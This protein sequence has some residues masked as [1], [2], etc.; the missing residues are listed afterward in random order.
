M[1]KKLLIAALILVAVVCAFASCKMQNTKEIK[2]VT[3]VNV[4]EDPILVGHFDEAGIE[5]VITYTDDTTDRVPVTESLCPSI[6]QRYLNEEGSFELT[7]LYRGFE[8]SFSV[9]MHIENTWTIRFFNAFG[10]VVKTVVM[11]ELSEGTPIPP[12]AEE[13]YC[14]GYI[15]LGTYDKDFEHATESMDVYG[16]Y[17]KT[18]TVDFYNGRNVLVSHQVVKEG[19]NATAPTGN[20]IQVPSYDFIGWDN[21]YTDIHADTVV[22]GIYTKMYAPNH[23]SVWDGTIATSYDGGLGTS[24]DP[25]RIGSASQLARMAGQTSSTYYVLTADID[26]AGRPWT[27]KEFSGYLDGRGHTISNVTINSTSNYVGF[28]SQFPY[29]ATVQNVN[30]KGVNITASNNNSPSVGGIVGHAGS[31]NSTITISNCTVTGKITLNTTSDA[32]VGG[33]AGRFGRNSSSYY[34]GTI[35]NV[36]CDVDITVTHLGASSSYVYAGGIVGIGREMKS[37][38]DCLALGD[39]SLSGFTTYRVWRVG[40]Y[41]TGSSDRTFSGYYYN[42]EQSYLAGDATFDDGSFATA[43]S[44]EDLNTAA[45]YTDVMGL[46]ATKWDLTAL[47]IEKKIIP[48][49]RVYKV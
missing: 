42:A 17:E 43:V 41:T 7:M 35:S 5:L 18:Y 14:E 11:S 2:S 48:R 23:V 46:D 3:A 1:K 31:S 9:S 45:F 10:E 47:D 28:F 21:E 20:V 4:P 12:T 32:Y 8:V 33:V 13:M 24:A 36:I 6:Y 15:F 27:P 19:E 37:M 39:V 26:L 30:F 29:G 49:L 44:V 40:Y 34:Y 22:Y 25:Y 38:T 16:Q